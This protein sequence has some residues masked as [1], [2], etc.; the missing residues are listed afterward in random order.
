MLGAEND[1]KSE[2]MLEISARGWVRGKAGRRRRE[3]RR[4]ITLGWHLPIV[5]AK[6]WVAIHRNSRSNSRAREARKNAGLSIY[7]W[8]TYPFSTW[9]FPDGTG[10]TCI[11]NKGIQP[12]IRRFG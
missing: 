6:R 12:A 10:T 11:H 5:S 4:G 9:L 3:R 7:D 1:P 2:S 8:S